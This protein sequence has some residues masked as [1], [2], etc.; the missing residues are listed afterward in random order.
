MKYTKIWKKNSSFIGKKFDSEPFYGDND[1]YIKTKIKSYGDKRNPNFQDKKVPK[2]NA[3]YKFLSLTLL[4]S[5]IRV[6]K[7]YHSQTLLEECKYEIKKNKIENLI[8]N[9]F[10]SGSSDESNSKPDSEPDSEP[11]RKPDSEPYNES[12][13]ELEKPSKKSESD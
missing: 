7:K 12:N 13:N 2:E 5:V 4:D 9:E 6:N 8:K 11:D 1:K 3:S 10:D